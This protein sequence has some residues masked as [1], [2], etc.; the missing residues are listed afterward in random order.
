MRTWVR[1][2]H[3]ITSISEETASKESNTLAFLLL[4]SIFL[5]F[6][7]FQLLLF[8]TFRNKHEQKH[9]Y[10]PK[11][12]KIKYLCLWFPARASSRHPVQTFSARH[13]TTERPTAA[14]E[15]RNWQLC[16]TENCVC[17][18]P[19]TFKCLPTFMRIQ[20]WPLNLNMATETTERRDWREKST[21]T[22]LRTSTQTRRLVQHDAE[23]RITFCD[24]V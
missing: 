6:V 11:S 8:N 1:H 2:I 12:L 17:W 10:N 15:K 14:S 19:H 7:L 18:K 20:I 4:A 16:C 22:R 13:R 3:I 23:V 9:F 5:W 21:S 24:S